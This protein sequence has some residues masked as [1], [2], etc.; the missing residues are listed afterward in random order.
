MFPL[1][2]GHLP[3]GFRNGAISVLFFIVLWSL[4]KTNVLISLSPE[5]HCGKMNGTQQ[6]NG[7]K[8]V[9]AAILFAIVAI[10]TPAD[11]TGAER[12]KEAAA[13]PTTLEEQ[14]H[15]VFLINEDP[16]NYEAHETI[17]PFAEMLDREHGF[18][19]TVIQGE[20]DLSAFR[21]PGLEEAL[22]EADLL[23]VFFRRIALSHEQL[24]AIKSYLND[25]H[26]LVGIRTANH[27]F[28]VRSEDGEIP[29]GYEDWWDFVP[30]ILGC[31]N[32]GYGSSEIGTEVAVVPEAADHPILEG[33]EP[34]QWHS[35]GNVYHVAPLLD[36]E[37]TVLLT[38]T[39]GD[40][41]EP[42]AWTRMAGES[43]VFYTSLGYPDDFEVPQ[44]RTLLINGIRWALD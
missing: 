19:T 16:Y 44:F 17:P 33:F 34:A 20:G 28:S 30:D 37:A 23:V 8:V 15:I 1:A 3:H 32:R 18:Q 36:E 25:G 24:G 4:M 13:A 26:P 38:G 27:A 39:A 6:S 10:Y 42:I 9:A 40:D 11:A 12:Q 41:V 43:R 21:F 2:P 5:P 35:T 29:E 7:W 31:E 14:P 22:A